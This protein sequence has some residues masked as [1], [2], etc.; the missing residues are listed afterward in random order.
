[1]SV[2][3]TLLIVMSPATGVPTT[4]QTVEAYL[5]VVSSSVAVYFWQVS[6]LYAGTGGEGDM[7]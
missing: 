6:R 7:P 5:I 3:L 2:R 1:L 4:T